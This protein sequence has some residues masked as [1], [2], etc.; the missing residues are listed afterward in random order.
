MSDEGVLTYWKKSW[1]SMNAIQKVLRVCYLGVLGFVTY[2]TL[3]K[4]SQFVSS[5]AEVL[6]LVNQ[7]ELVL[8][9]LQDFNTLFVAWSFIL[10]SFTILF[11][12]I[13]VM[14]V[15]GRI[16]RFLDNFAAWYEEVRTDAE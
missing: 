11:T 13:A 10:G 5:M 9:T 4:G 7:E 14:E 3:D 15:L 1:S 12:A 2:K 8:L 16:F 6:S